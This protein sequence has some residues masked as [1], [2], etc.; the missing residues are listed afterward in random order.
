MKTTVIHLNLISK[1][2]MSFFYT[3]FDT[4]FDTT[5]Y[6]IFKVTGFTILLYTIPW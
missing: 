3:F 2:P 6:S 4:I 1:F 5:F